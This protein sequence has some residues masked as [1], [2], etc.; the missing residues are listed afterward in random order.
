[1]IFYGLGTIVGA[2]IYVLIGEI[3]GRAGF[4]TP[5]SFVGAALIA[6]FTGLTYAELVGRF[7][8]SAGE[9][10]YVEKA[11]GQPWLTQAIGWGVILTGIVSASTLIKGFAGYYLNLLGGQTEIIIFFAVIGI[12]LLAC[13]GVKG[14]VGVAVFIT[15]LELIGLLLVVLA[16]SETLSNPET[17]EIWWREG[18]KEIWTEDTNPSESFAWVGVVSAA[19]LAFYAFIGFEDMVN[20]AEEVKDAS[21]NLPKAIVIAVILATM[22]YFIVALVV[23][24]AV[25]HTTLANSTAPLTTVV[26]Q[27]SWFPASLLS[28]IS[29]VAILNGAIVQ[30][31]MAPRVIYG[32][33][34]KSQYFKGLAKIN[35]VTQSPV[36][37]TLWVALVV[38]IFALWLPLAQLAQLTSGII[39]LVFILV[40]SALIKIKLKDSKDTKNKTISKNFRVPLWVPIVGLFTS[41]LLLLTQFVIL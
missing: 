40:N 13:S 29:L 16:T 34:Q 12:A 31:L 23:T 17:W 39:L 37:A 11:F 22:I 20:M 33:T 21:K 9:A 24:V 41:L 27:A 8:K 6:G 30:F 19:F 36:N 18:W 28:V 10:V 26:E 32:I 38:L 4:W 15:I 35:S 5:L 3:A 1:M 14:S 2:G 7:P 25:D